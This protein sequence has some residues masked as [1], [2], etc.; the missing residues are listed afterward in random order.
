MKSTVIDNLLAKR[1]T[2]EKHAMLSIILWLFLAMLAFKI[3]LDLLATQ[4]P[5]LKE[6][7][8]SCEVGK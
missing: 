3:A 8:Y 2:G 5:S 1:A 7:V 6:R 4:I